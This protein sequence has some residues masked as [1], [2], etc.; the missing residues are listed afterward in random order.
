MRISDWSSDVC[1]SDLQLDNN[2]ALAVLASYLVKS[3]G[4]PSLGHLC[5]RDLSAHCARFFGQEDR[6]RADVVQV[7]AGCIRPAYRAVEAQL[8]FVEPSPFS[9][10]QRDRQSV[11]QG[12]SWSVSAD[13]GV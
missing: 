12:K 9:P 3:F 2:A 1:S 13:I 11:A 8:A 6:Q 10:A 7:D 5:E 4:E